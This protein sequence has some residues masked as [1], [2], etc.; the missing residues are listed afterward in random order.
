MMDGREIKS[1]FSSG[2]QDQIT[3]V[4][5]D[6]PHTFSDLIEAQAAQDRS[7]KLHT[8]LQIWAIQQSHERDLRKLY[9]TALIIIIAVQ[10][11]FMI[12]FFFLIGFRAFS[13]SE[14][15]FSIFYV[16]VFGEITALIL[17]VTKYLFPK[18]ANSKMLEFMKEL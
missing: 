5:N 11:I 10:V 9:A 18:D 8:I 1:I 17:I 12:L 15:Q 7:D 13:I 4:S 14:N 16:S 3:D 6:T 2:A